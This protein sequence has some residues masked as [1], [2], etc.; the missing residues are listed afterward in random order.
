MSQDI[1]QRVA[2]FDGAH[3]EY[4][5]AGDGKSVVFFHGGGG[6]EHKAAFIPALAERFRVLAPSRPNYDGSTAPAETTRDVAEVMAGFIQHTVGG[7]VHLTAESAGG[8][9]A[10]WLAILHPDLVE[11]LTLAA[12]AAFLQRSAQ[13]HD[14]P[15]PSQQ[16]MDERLF[17]K[18]PGWSSP[19]TADD[20]EKRRKNAMANMGRIMSPDGN[21]DLRDRLGEIKA[22]TLVL[23]GTEDKVISPE[24]GAIYQKEI[25]HAYLMYVYGAAHALPVSATK[26]FVELTTD[27]IERGE[28]FLVNQRTG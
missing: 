5:E 9:P 12:P 27:F 7:P 14:S 3:I 6:V 2:E 11:S 10:C 24:Q 4:L 19:P 16:E 22:P 1:S 23:W 17:G 25:P 13:G 15:P 8:A 26:Q 20:S 21:K 18:N 28:A